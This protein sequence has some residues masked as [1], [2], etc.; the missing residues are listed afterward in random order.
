MRTRS[1]TG[2]AALQTE[3]AILPAD[4]LRRIAE[5]DASLGGLDSVSYHLPPGERLSE[6][7]SRSWSR[8]QGSWAAF[9]SAKD[10]LPEADAGTTLTREKWLLPLFQELGYGRL[11]PAKPI[12]IGE[13]SYGISHG[14]QH[15]P[16]HLV[17]F[18]LDLDKRQPGAAGAS[19]SS[20]HSLLQ[21]LLN[22]S[23]EHLWGIVSN[24]LC[25]RILRDNASLSRQAFVE[26]DLEAIFDGELYA[27]FALLWLLCHQSRV[28]GDEPGSCCLEKWSK[29]AKEQGAR[30]FDRLR[31]GVEAAISALGAGFLVH[32]A[33]SQLR[34]R[35]R[36]GALET[37][38]Y[39]RELLRHVYRVLFLFVAEDRQLLQ[40]STSSPESKTRYARYFS[41]QR[42]RRLSNRLRGS[43]HGDL[44]VAHRLVTAWLG[45]MTGRKEMGLPALGSFLF[46]DAAVA[47]TGRCQLSNSDF[48]KV[49]RALAFAETD[50]VRRPVDYK[51]IG[52]EEL[53]SV[54]ESLLELVPRVDI[55]SG[56]FELG[57][58]AGHERKTT[59]SY[60]T[61]D[62][63]VQALLDTALRPV[64]DTA[65]LSVDPESALLGLRVCD[66]ACGSGHF[67]V[68][69]AHHIAY[70]LA[71]VRAGLSEPTP[72]LVRVALRDV[73]GRCLFGVDLNP[74]A[75]E[76]CK[77]SLWM[78]T[79]EPGKPLSFLDHHI[80]LGNALVGAT[81][82]VIAA[83]I[84]DGAFEPL[85]GDDASTCREL[86]K[87]NGAERSSGQT[88]M[89]FQPEANEF[90]GQV[91]RGL[92]EI[93]AIE[94][95]TL[96]GIAARELRWT[97]LESSD[98]MRRARL[99]ADAWCS[100][101]FWKK[102]PG[103]V[104][105]LTSGQLATLE[106]ADTGPSTEREKEIRRLAEM[107]RCFHWHVAFP[108]V[109]DGRRGFD[110]V[111][112]NPPWVSYTGR[113]QVSISAR[114][115]SLLR[116][117]FPE[118]A[119]WPATHSAF[120]LLASELCSEG[121]RIGMVLPRQVADLDAYKAVRDSVGARLHLVPPIVDIGED[122]FPGVTQPVGLFSFAA[123]KESG[124]LAGRLWVRETKGTRDTAAAD[125]G[126]PDFGA[127]LADRPR[128]EAKTFTDPGVHTGNVS[129]KIILDDA[130]L[131]D[132]RFERVREGRD[133]V[134]FGCASPRKWL[135]VEPSL[136]PGEYCTI[137]AL[138]RY[139]GVPILVRQTAD[140]PIAAR[141]TERTY[142]R[143]SLLACG[144]VGG[145]PDTVVVAFL[146]SA[147]YAWLHR[148]AAMDANQKAF[149]QVKIRH[150]QSLPAIPVEALS[151]ST[152]G[153]RVSDLMDVVVQELETITRD[154]EERRT[155]RLLTLERYVLEAFDL[156]AEAATLLWRAVNDPMQARS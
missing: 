97:A 5:G 7:V 149:P 77:V 95:S 12:T 25:L 23:E 68:A 39:Y 75:V 145:V 140:R 148:K 17:S 33:N 118:I 55:N 21:E 63:L 153:G 14:W 138:A 49:I 106:V 56:L 15:T 72:D 103:S 98:S 91:R 60:Y 129:K 88:A 116:A 28:E 44:F 151:R 89:L 42:L 136:D 105:P 85:E 53:G 51:N 45:S 47:E 147:L 62:S 52:A 93:D 1:Q 24:G 40:S 58:T 70:R 115:L 120:L 109:C 86:K 36:N 66:P 48:L 141:H 74:M 41:T 119:R 154:D 46:A 18:R 61:P 4:L 9:K 32:P 87:R 78:E 57:L 92:T 11:T 142:F 114:T 133:I 64:L 79:L 107:N 76:L 100:A 143:N 80:R 35:L 110:V 130:P 67:L 38:D 8:L 126:L 122:A 113:Q 117:R 108:N 50:G 84:P 127:L 150:L 83:G 121:G 31:T 104:L 30:V 54:Y 6:A 152:S 26:F 135:W 112:G 137:R 19:K 124:N 96:E 132:E 82:D 155:D 94:D 37:Q 90:V 81:R 20:P 111:V 123:G 134:P 27:D 29:A 10:R 144:G 69:A 99:A 128:F 101:F 13:K 43:R 131:G 2:F 3:G 125:V 73:V 34:D 16:L 156:P 65:C 102:W 59:G 22:R 146:N 139:T 71:Y